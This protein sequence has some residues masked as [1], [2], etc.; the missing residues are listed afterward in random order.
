MAVGC[1]LVV[2]A[3]ANAFGIAILATDDHFGGATLKDA[4]VPGPFLVVLGL[5]IWGSLWLRSA[6][7]PSGNRPALDSSSHRQTSQVLPVS[8]SRVDVVVPGGVL[9]VSRSGLETAVEDADEPVGKLA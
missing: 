6:T 2:A 5:V 4:Y 8:S 3:V 9:V 1:L 7:T